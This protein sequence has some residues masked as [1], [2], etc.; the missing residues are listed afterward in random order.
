MVARRTWLRGICFIA[1]TCATLAAAQ[2]G[3]AAAVDRGA[4]SVNV[5]ASGLN[6]PRGIAM[7]H[8]ALLVAEAGKGGHGPCR[9]G[10][11][12]RTCFGL[13]GAITHLVNG[14]P[15]RLVDLPSLASPDGSAAFGPHDVGF[16][17]DG[18][19]YGTI[20]LAYPPEVRA[21]FGPRARLLG[22]LVRIDGSGGVQDVADLAAYEAKH[23]P[24]GLGAESDPYGLLPEN[25]H[26]IVTDAAANDLLKVTNSGHVSTLAV[27]P[28]RMVDFRGGQIPM[29]AVPTSVVRGP[30]GALYVS[31]LTGFPFP[32][33]G[34]R[35]F[36]VVPGQRPRVYA[37][38]FTNIIDIAF[39]DDGNLY[40]VEIAHNSLLSDAPYG[41]LLRVSPSGD[42][43]VLMG[44]DANLFFP[45]SVL[46][47]GNGN[48]LLTNCGVCPGGGQV[49]EVTP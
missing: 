1:V 12:G 41:E 21:S 22:H 8:G 49:L 43:T 13:T 33:G 3:P 20:G 29:Q 28:N 16:G 15:N 35:V 6:S 26:S 45:T 40:V 31:E 19:M 38:G 14:V 37:R 30:D 4:P 24:D 47:E 36:R 32:K 11:L 17:S 23:D 34:A 48:M 2:P 10:A 9:P 42:T 39:D 46:L 18:A 27:F 44:K 25:G 5:V 7:S